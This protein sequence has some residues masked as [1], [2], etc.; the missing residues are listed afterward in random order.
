MS[1]PS[2]FLLSKVDNVLLDNVRDFFI[3]SMR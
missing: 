2:A 1:S 3:R